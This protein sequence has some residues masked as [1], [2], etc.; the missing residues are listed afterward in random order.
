VLAALIQMEDKVY[1]LMGISEVSKFTTYQPA[2]LFTVR[3]FKE[4]KDTEKLNRKPELVRIKALPQQM[5]LQAA[6]QHFNMPS[7][8]FDELAILNGMLLNEQ[9]SKATLIKVI[10]K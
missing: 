3:N 1:S 6:F 5:T 9:L 2:L 8:R 10:G 7:E 4:L